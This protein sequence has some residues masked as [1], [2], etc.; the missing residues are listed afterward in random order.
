MD[1]STMMYKLQSALK[2]KGIIVC[3]NTYQ[4]YSNEKER[5]IKMYV[6]KRGEKQLLNTASQIQV[7][8]KLNEIWQE[9][10]NEEGNKRRKRSYEI[11][12]PK[13][14]KICSKLYENK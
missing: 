9:V 10:K 1:T 12:K 11:P 5:F 2:Q 7:L 8:H 3:I 14:N 13:T 4:F 6:L